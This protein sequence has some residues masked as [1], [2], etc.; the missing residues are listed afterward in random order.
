MAHIGRQ[1]EDIGIYW[2]GYESRKMIPEIKLNLPLRDETERPLNMAEKSCLS[3]PADHARSTHGGHGPAKRLSL[4]L[5]L[6]I[7]H[8]MSSSKLIMTVK[9]EAPDFEIDPSP[10]KKAKTTT[11]ILKWTEEEI[12]LLCDLRSNNVEWE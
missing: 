7:P 12:Q 11:S 4:F 10:K 1:V 5:Y 6:N 9:T 2:E 3:A 8:G